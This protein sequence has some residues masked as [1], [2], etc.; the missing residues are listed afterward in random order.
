MPSRRSAISAPAHAKLG[1]LLRWTALPV[2][3]HVALVLDVGD[4]DP[5]GPEPR[6]GEIAELIEKRDALVQSGRCLVGP[7]DIVEQ[8]GALRLLGAH[9][10]RPITAARL[11]VEPGEPAADPQL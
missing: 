10:V 2:G 11:G 4:A 3:E 1:E 7:G 9:E 5:A 6:R 8:G